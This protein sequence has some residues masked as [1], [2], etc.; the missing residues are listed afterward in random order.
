MNPYKTC[1]HCGKTIH[2]PGH[3]PNTWTDA[4]A[5]NNGAFCTAVEGEPHEPGEYK[6]VRDTRHFT[7]AVRYADRAGS[8]GTATANLWVAVQHAAD[9]LEIDLD[10]ALAEES[11]R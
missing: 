5:I 6:P 10:A 1:R 7:N 11:D 9:L 4:H 3:T 2:Q 8:L